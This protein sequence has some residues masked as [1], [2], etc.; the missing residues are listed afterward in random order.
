MKNKLS[1]KT[2]TLLG[3][4]ILL[5]FIGVPLFLQL[6]LIPNIGNGSDDGWLGFFGGYLGSIVSMIGAFLVIY[7]QLRA[8]ERNRREDLDIEK[9]SRTDEKIDNT[10]FNLLNFHNNIQEKFRADPRGEFSE[11]ILSKIER[12]HVQMKMDITLQK[13]KRFIETKK[14]AFLNNIDNFQSKCQESVEES[15]IPILVELI[16]ELREAIRE[17]DYEMILRFFKRKKHCIDEYESTPDLVDDIM[18]SSTNNSE[19]ERAYRVEQTNRLLLQYQVEDVILSELENPKN[20]LFQFQKELLSNSVDELTLETDRKKLIEKSFKNYY[21]KYGNYFR[22]VHRIVKY[23]NDNVDDI[24]QKKNYLGFLRAMLNEKELIV[25]Y[26]NSFYTKRGEGLGDEL[27]KTTFFGGPDDLK[28]DN[29]YFSHFSK[30]LL[31]WEK[32]DVKIMR[33]FKY[34]EQENE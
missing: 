15:S 34:P 21:G 12:E 30:E 32:D 25:L 3:L 14:E 7:I 20:A 9:K 5:M 24:T 2:K 10:F 23:V 19:G 18:D 27:K 11:Q 26:Y 8:D 31:L 22:I 28:L 1:M 13:K 29:G 4:S 6:L 17:N 33:S 16:D